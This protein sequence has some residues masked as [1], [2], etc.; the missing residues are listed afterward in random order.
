M[1]QLISGI[2]QSDNLSPILFNIFIDDVVKLFNPEICGDISLD[3]TPVN[4]LIYADD[5][6]IISTSQEGLQKSLD[7]LVEYCNSWKLEINTRKTKV[8]IFRPTKKIDNYSFS[9]YGERVDIVNNITYLGISLSYTGNFTGAMKNVKLNGMRALFKLLSSLKSSKINNATIN[10]KL[11]DSTIK[12][13]LFSS[14][15]C[16]N[17]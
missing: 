11:F 10:I 14:V 2:K 17:P 9:I 7:K 4:S 15:D 12:P 1:V 3:G 8:I 13:I 6:L 16:P 5:L